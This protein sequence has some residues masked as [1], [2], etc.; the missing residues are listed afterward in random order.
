MERSLREVAGDFSQ[1]PDQC[2]E[3]RRS[4]ILFTCGTALHVVPVGPRAPLRGYL[5]A[6]AGAVYQNPKSICPRHQM[7]LPRVIKG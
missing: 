5:K 6:F 1:W 2:E 3:D 7:L 4:R